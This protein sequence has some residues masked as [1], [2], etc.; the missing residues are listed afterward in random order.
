[1]NKLQRNKLTCDDFIFQEIVN[2]EGQQQWV[3]MLYRPLNSENFSAESFFK[4]MSSNDQ[5][6]FDME[7]LTI[8]AA[9]QEISPEVLVS[10]NI[11]P[12][13]VSNNLFWNKVYDLVACG[14]LNPKNLC[15][16]V[17]EKGSLRDLT[18]YQIKAI[19]SLRAQGMKIAL[20]DFGNGV[21]H[22]ELLKHD[23]VDI[24]KIVNN[25]VNEDTASTTCSEKFLISLVAFAQSLGLTTVLEGIETDDDFQQ[26]IQFGCQNFQGYLF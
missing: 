13:S 4:N 5:L 6:S 2:L 20:D 23:L 8:V 19:S 16:E 9:K 3:E 18:S 14:V 12:E 24:V 15:V 7:I 26:G 1:M 25:K 22:W 17:L 11:S 21:A 10:V